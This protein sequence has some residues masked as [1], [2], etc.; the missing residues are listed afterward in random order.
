MSGTNLE[1]PE[2]Q[3]SL[4]KLQIEW[5]SAL[6]TAFPRFIDTTTTVGRAVAALVER[7][8]L[9]NGFVRMA[10]PDHQLHIPAMS[11]QDRGWADSVW[12]EVPRPQSLCASGERSLSE[13]E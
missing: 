8:I 3:S 12:R 1:A 10:N 7:A 5:R 11:R 6:R 9:P 2:R 13:S 4:V